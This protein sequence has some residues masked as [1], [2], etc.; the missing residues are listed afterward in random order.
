MGIY[1]LLCVMAH[2]YA[3]ILL[4][5]FYFLLFFWFGFV[6]PGLLVAQLESISINDNIPSLASD[7]PVV[8]A[9]FVLFSVVFFLFGE[10]EP[11]L[12]H[13]VLRVFWCCS[14]FGFT[15]RINFIYCNCCA[16]PT[17]ACGSRLC[18]TRDNPYMMYGRLNLSFPNQENKSMTFGFNVVTILQGLV[19]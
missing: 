11:L 13:P 9:P 19:L 4:M 6:F 8:P 5:V 3:F 16:C 17:G 15:L 1:T 2:V 7:L 10:I 12:P 18:L 14:S